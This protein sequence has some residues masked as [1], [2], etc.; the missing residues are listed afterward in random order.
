VDVPGPNGNERHTWRQDVDASRDAQID[1]TETPGDIAVSGTVRV[2]GANG[3]PRLVGIGMRDS[4]GGVYNSQ[5][6]QDGSFDFRNMKFK[7]G[8]YEL[9]VLNLPG[10]FIRS[11]NAE[12][13]SVFGSSG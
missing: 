13:A 9:G 7:P 3:L 12:G 1:L 2:A 10:F 4:H 6:A 5:S 8:R 11:L